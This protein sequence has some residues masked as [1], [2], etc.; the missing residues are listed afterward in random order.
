MNLTSTASDDWH[1]ESERVGMERDRY[2]RAF[3]H[4]DT[5]HSLPF[6]PPEPERPPRPPEYLRPP[7]EEDE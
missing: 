3:R 2:E 6:L 7:P 1:R 4:G 5:F